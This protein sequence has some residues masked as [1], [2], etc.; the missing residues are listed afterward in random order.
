LPDGIFSLLFSGVVEPEGTLAATF[1]MSL[2]GERYSI[3]KSS[4]Q[5]N[6]QAISCRIFF[7][8]VHF[9]WS[10]NN[11]T[12]LIF[13]WIHDGVKMLVIRHLNVN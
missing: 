1:V 13:S 6:L 12:F 4:K 8:L 5:I 2:N 10:F 9:L 7:R 11:L 3:L